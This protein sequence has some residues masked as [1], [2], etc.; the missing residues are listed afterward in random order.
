MSEQPLCGS[1][2]DCAEYTICGNAW[3]AHLSGDVPEPV[4]IASPGQTITCPQCRKII[5][6][7]KAIKRYKEPSK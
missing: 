6:A 7:I 2:P 5:D 1:M 4:E 3:D